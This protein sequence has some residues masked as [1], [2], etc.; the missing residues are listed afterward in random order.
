MTQ[1][2]VATHIRRQGGVHIR[3]DA[4]QRAR[5]VVWDV[6]REKRGLLINDLIVVSGQEHAIVKQFCSQ[7]ERAGYLWHEPRYA[8]CRFWLIHDTGRFAP[9]PLAGGRLIED[10]NKG[11]F[12]Q[13]SA[14]TRKWPD[15]P[16]P[17]GSLEQQCWLAMRMLRNFTVGELELVT[18]H[19]PQ[20]IDRWIKQLLSFSYVRQTEISGGEMGYQLPYHCATG[21]KAPAI[22]SDINRLFDF[23]TRQFFVREGK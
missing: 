15:N 9:S 1:L 3:R 12:Y 2:K 20:A 21:P 14:I 11:E 19:P 4:L 22:N 18:E 10:F 16:P 13:I 17:L 7:L 6:L 8:G 5:Q 23:N